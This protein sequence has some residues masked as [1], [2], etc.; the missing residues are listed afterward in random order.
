MNG[1]DASM[2]G[3]ADIDN[4]FGEF[5]D[6]SLPTNFWDPIFVETEPSN[7]RP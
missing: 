5:L 3:F 2:H 1:I 7:Q 4:L 6:L